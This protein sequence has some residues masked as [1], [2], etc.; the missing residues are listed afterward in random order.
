MFDRYPP[1]AAA[2]RCVPP[3]GAP[4]VGEPDF[5]PAGGVNKA[6]A[7]ALKFPVRRWGRGATSSCDAATPNTRFERPFGSADLAAQQGIAD[8]LVVTVAAV[9]RHVTS[10]FSKLALHQKPEDHRRVL[11]VVQYL[12]A[13]R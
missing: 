12:R 11:A 5:K 4:R 8:E 10:I 6:E 2:K 7:R 9:E 3:D 1:P 13:E